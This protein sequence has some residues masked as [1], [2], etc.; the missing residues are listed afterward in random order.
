[1]CLTNCL[2]LPFYWQLSLTLMDH[3]LGPNMPMLRVRVS[4]GYFL[5]LSEPRRMHID[6]HLPVEAQAYS[7]DRAQPAYETLIEPTVLGFRMQTKETLLAGLQKYDHTKM[8]IGG[9]ALRL[10]VTM[11]LVHQLIRSITSLL[12]ILFQELL[13]EVRQSRRVLICHC[14]SA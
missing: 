8:W 11:E 13:D 4:D 9:V 12:A 3:E 1:M 2:F 14:H 7:A 6:I 5:M 10:T